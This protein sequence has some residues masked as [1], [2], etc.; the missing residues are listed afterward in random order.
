[1]PE[2][3]DTSILDGASSAEQ[4]LR[5]LKQGK[6]L[7]YQAMI[8]E[9]PISTKRH[10]RRLIKR[11]RE[12]NFSVEEHY[13]GHEKVFALPPGE[14]AGPTVS[15]DLTEREALALTLAADATRSGSGPTPLDNALT[16][17]FDRLLRQISNA[18]K[19]FEPDD[20]VAHL[21]F[22]EASDVEIDSSV[23]MA[24]VRALS[25]R[26]A[27]RIDYYTAST[28]TRHEGREIEPWALARRGDSWLCVA[29]DPVKDEL[30]DFNLSRIDAIRPTSEGNPGG[31]YQIPED[32]DLEIY[33]IDRF[34]ALEGEEVHL[35]RLLVEP[36]L[37]PYFRSKQYHRTQQIHDTPKQD[38]ALS[39][40]SEQIVVSYEVSGLEE[41]EAFVRSWGEGV[42]VLSPPELAQRIV[43][44]ARKVVLRYE[45]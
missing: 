3:S 44:E 18:V 24:L 25:N 17:A 30:R 42:K 29:R 27:I 7:T 32:F 15:L 10:A 11:L 40:N 14:Q 9:L 38:S 31:D 19:S 8:E 35:V 1:M 28:N 34:E 2:S 12:A 41:M 20:L 21:H 26:Q 13:E 33:F 39:E 6:T 36:D 22:G 5:L 45:E 4:L 23:F 37:A 43:R 16:D